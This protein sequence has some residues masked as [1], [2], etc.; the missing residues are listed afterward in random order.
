MVSLN[1]ALNLILIWPLAEVGFAISTSVAA[2]VQVLILMTIF[3]RR[4]APLGWRPLLAT[5][6]RTMLS[7][8]VMAGVVHLTLAQMPG[9]Y[10]LVDQLICVGAPVISGAAAYCGSY[11][12]LGGRELGMLVSGRIVD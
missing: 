11:W 2:A 7:T 5:A 9:A 6:A 3:S 1:L 8:L 4:R 12:L 10:R